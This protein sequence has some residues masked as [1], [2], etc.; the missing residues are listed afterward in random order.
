MLGDSRCHKNLLIRRVLAKRPFDL[1]QLRVS[2]P[3]TVEINQSLTSF[4]PALSE[5]KGF[6]Y[7]LYDLYYFFSFGHFHNELPSILTDFFWGF[8]INDTC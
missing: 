5:G 7:C 6:F 2:I 8:N 3:A 1:I 4:A